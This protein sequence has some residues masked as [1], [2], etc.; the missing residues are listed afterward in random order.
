MQKVDWFR[1]SHALW[2]KVQVAFF[3]FVIFC[4]FRWISTEKLLN[5]AVFVKF[6]TFCSQNCYFSINAVIFFLQIFRIWKNFHRIA[7][8]L[9]D[10]FDARKSQKSGFENWTTLG[11]FV[12]RPKF[13]ACDLFC[14]E[15]PCIHYRTTWTML[16][17]GKCDFPP[18]TL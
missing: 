8:G 10:K 4:R 7:R 12:K 2:K 14:V 1:L 11:K 9:S 17:G 6:C 15:E 16:R 5:L 18:L 13:A 3:V